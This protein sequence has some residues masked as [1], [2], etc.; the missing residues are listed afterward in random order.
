[1]KNESISPQRLEELANRAYQRGYAVFSPFLNLD[2]IS[3]LKA[4][5][6]QSGYRLFGG[7][8]GCDRRVAGFGEDIEDNSFP[9][10]C[11]EISPVSKRF[12]DELN[13]RDFLGSL[14]NLGISRSTLG[15][16][17]VKDNTAYLFC[18]DSISEYIKENLTRVKHTTVSCKE[19]EE[20]PEFINEP[21]EAEERFTPSL[22][23]DAVISSVF[24]LSRSEASRLFSESRVFVN[25]RLLQKESALLKEGD[26][27]SVRGCGKFIFEGELRSTKKN[28]LVIE[29][30]IYK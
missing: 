11:I 15:D 20:L 4:L 17:I 18:L 14:M 19:V 23:A 27:V 10:K 29:V 12:S 28:R 9:I 21:P 6:L 5:H 25:S 8:D 16:I 22:R 26:T 24:K 30:R 3:T 13:H 2:E 1:M 7:T